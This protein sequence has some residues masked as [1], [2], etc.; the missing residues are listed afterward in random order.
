[1][2]GFTIHN[3]ATGQQ[4]GVIVWSHESVLYEGKAARGEF[5]YQ[6]I[7][8][9]KYGLVHVLWREKERI[10]YIQKNEAGW[11]QPTDIV[12][13][14]GKTIKYVSVAIDQNGILHLV[15]DEFGEI[16]Y[17][18]APAWQ[19]TYVKRWSEE[20]VIGQTG[21]MDT[22]LRIGADQNNGLHV[23]FVDMN[24]IEGKTTPGNLYHFSSSDGGQ[25][26]SNYH[27]V[28]NVLNGEIVTYPRMVF[29]DRGNIHIVWSQMIP[30]L[31]GFQEGVYYSRMSIS[32]QTTTPPKAIDLN[33]VEKN[34]MMA[35]QIAVINGDEIHTVWA[36]GE[37]TW[38]CSSVSMDGG[39]TW[40][41]PQHIFGDLVGLSTWDALFVDGSDNLY[42]MG[43]LRRPQ[44]LWYSPYEG[45]N[46][47]DPPLIASQDE[48]MQL[49]EIIMVAVGLGNKIHAV[50]NLEG[51]I[52][53]MP[54][55]SSA[56]KEQALPI[57]SQSQQKIVETQPTATETP[58]QTS[59]PAS[60]TPNPNQ[61]SGKNADLTSNSKVLSI[62][63]FAVIVTLSAAL[64]AKRLVRK[65]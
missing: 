41:T 56:R 6:N 4:P 62:S 27:Q 12:Y 19:A 40:S 46:F 23:L 57:P 20:H 16:H 38:R 26:W 59:V 65:F 24:G 18:S 25:T 58:E 63:L 48:N 52:I 55:I 5:F 10:Y 14:P 36:C 47:F 8:A 39:N 35:I 45:S 31:S 42:W 61:Q 2:F 34:W 13:A 28:S 32:N 54:G 15:W 33:T 11:T 43:V 50:S 29:D 21:L 53:Y 3:P 30:E 1:M 17:K 9:D 60:I 49:G 44:A 37:K 22:P 7:V 64:G 51:K